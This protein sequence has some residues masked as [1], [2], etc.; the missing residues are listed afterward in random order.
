[1]G[2]GGNSSHDPASVKKSNL[3][4]SFSSSCFF[5][6]ALPALTILQSGHGCL[7]SKVFSSATETDSVL[8][9][10]T[11]MPSQAADC[12]NAQ[13]P[14]MTITSA[15]TTDNL[16]NRMNTPGRCEKRNAVSMEPRIGSALI[17]APR[18]ARQLADR[19]N[20]AVPRCRPA[21]EETRDCCA[22][23]GVPNQS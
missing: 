7:P 6:E 15:S 4:S 9:K 14:P 5:S 3:V 22:G 10:L 1:M 23:A 19:R 21:D 16:L 18:P 12:S 13:C 17:P 8:E 2:L 11:A 20:E